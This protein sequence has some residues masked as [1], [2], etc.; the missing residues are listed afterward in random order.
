LSVIN[1]VKVDLLWE[2][3][4]ILFGRKL[5][6]IGHYLR[7]M[8]MDDTL[9]FVLGVNKKSNDELD[10]YII[11]PKGNLVMISECFIKYIKRTIF[12]HNN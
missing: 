1:F 11:Q 7:N 3:L 12:L 5:K 8:K 2:E 6:D 10:S 9:E 4:G